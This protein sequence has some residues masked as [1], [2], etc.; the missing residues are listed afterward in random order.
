[1]PSAKQRVALFA[2][3]LAGTLAYGFQYGIGGGGQNT[4]TLAPEVQKKGPAVRSVSGVVLDQSDNPIARA[5]VYLKNTKTLNVKTSITTDSGKYQFSGLAPNQ[6]YELYAGLNGSKSPTK[7]L[8]GFDSREKTTLNLHIDQNQ[9]N[10]QKADEKTE[11]NQKT[12]NQKK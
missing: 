2:L 8:S 6:D 9:K 1:M 11:Q 12:E 4:G 5:V 10:D 3:L 7:T